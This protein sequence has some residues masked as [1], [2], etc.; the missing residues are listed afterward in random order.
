MLEMDLIDDAYLH[1]V[2]SRKPHRLPKILGPG[3]CRPDRTSAF[4]L[5]PLDSGHVSNDGERHQSESFCIF[6]ALSIEAGTLWI[7]WSMARDAR[8]SD[9]IGALAP[10]IFTHEDTRDCCTPNMRPF[11]TMIIVFC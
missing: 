2:N 4:L 1:S 10:G 7:P 9:G 6:H 8:S 5:P 11:Y 3:K